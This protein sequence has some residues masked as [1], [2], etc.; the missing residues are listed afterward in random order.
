MVWLFSVVLVAKPLQRTDCFF[1]KCQSSRIA[2]DEGAHNLTETLNVYNKRWKYCLSKQWTLKNQFCLSI[3]QSQKYSNRQNLTCA[4]TVSVNIIHLSNTSEMILHR[5][6]DAVRIWWWLPTHFPF[7]QST[8]DIYS[9]LK[10]STAGRNMRRSHLG[11]E[12]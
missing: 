1:K 6:E 12:C 5:W 11:V 4:I 8:S 2:T 9:Q 10:Y 3:F 7:T